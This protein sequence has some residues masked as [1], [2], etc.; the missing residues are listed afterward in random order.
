M[1]LWRFQGSDH[2]AACQGNLRGHARAA[3]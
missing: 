3:G 1:R 2:D